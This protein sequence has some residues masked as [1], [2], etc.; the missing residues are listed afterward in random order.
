MTRAIR[1]SPAEHSSPDVEQY[2]SELE[3]LTAENARLRAR[4]DKV[5]DEKYWAEQEGYHCGWRDAMTQRQR[6]YLGGYLG[7]YVG[8]YDYGV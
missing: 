2:Q 4:V 5:E 8:G 6:A 7:G 3:R 1:F